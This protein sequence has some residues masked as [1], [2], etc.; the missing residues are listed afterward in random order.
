[1]REQFRDLNRFFPVAQGANLPDNMPITQSQINALN[2]ATFSAA[3]DIDTWSQH[4]LGNHFLGWFNANLAG[5]DSWQGVTLVDTAANRLG[6]H[7]FWNNIDDLTGGTATPFQFLCLM[8]IFSN[9]CRADFIPKSER[10]GRPGF[11]GLSYLFDA[12]PSLKRSYNTLP[13]NKPA[14]D[15]FRSA[16]FN[17][18]HGPKPLGSRLI[19]TT[20]TRWRVETFPRSDFPTD[21]TPTVTGYILEADFMKFR[22]RGFIQ[23][24]GRANYLRLIDFVKHYQG[25]NNTL[26]FFAFQWRNLSPDVVADQSSNDDWDRLFAQSDLIVAA[27][28]IGIHNQSCGNYLALSGDPDHAVLNMGKRI[29]GGDVYAG[30][31]RDRMAQMINLIAA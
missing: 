22:G 24:T 26:D 17:A 3:E 2:T 8:G 13:G 14:F 30:K 28:A 15:C 7:A 25:A 12:I 21:P 20:D 1:M 4:T 6:F 23:T 5:K 11:P 29:S 19:N 9:E 16:A 18:V 31:F 10:M 27:K